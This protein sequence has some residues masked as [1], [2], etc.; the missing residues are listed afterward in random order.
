MK[1]L[2]II[3]PV[4]NEKNTL[5]GLL[6]S[7]ESSNIGPI[8]KE[9][10]IVD[11]FSTD[12]TRDL[13]R[14]LMKTN[15]YKIYFQDKNH[16]KGYA[17]RTGF[18]KAKGDY[19]LI[20]DADLEYNPKEYPN[21]LGPLIDG[22][23]DV[24]YGSRFVRNKPGGVL[25]FWHYV[26]NKFLTMFSN[27][28]TGLYLTD[29]E[30]C[31]KVF[32]KEAL[33]KIYPELRSDRFD[34]EPEITA[35][36]AEKR[37]RV[38]EVGVTYS[39]R[40]YDE[41]KKINWKDGFS[42]V[43]TIIK[44]KYRYSSFGKDKYKSTFFLLLILISLFSVLTLRP[45][46]AGDSLLYVDSIEV[47]KTGVQSAD[48]VPMMILTTYLGL[49]LIM[50]INY[51]TG[52]LAVSWILL[53]II[54]YI[55]TGVFFYS[56]LKRI[57]NDNKVAFIGSLFFATNYA[58]ITFGLGYLMDMGGWAAYIA[59]VYFS[60]RYL[61]TTERSNKF[62]YFSSILI[63]IGGLYKEY[64]FVAYAVVFGAILWKNWSNWKLII[65]KV[66]VTGLLSFTPFL[67]M[68]IFVF[69]KYN[70]YTYLDWYLFQKVYEFQ[71]RPVEFI[72]SF[73]S[74]YNFG[75]FLFLGGFYIFISKWKDILKDKKLV[76]ISLLLLSCSSVLLWPVV[77]R[78]LFITMPAVIIVSSL[79]I[80]KIEK[81][82]YLVYG[83]L[84][85]YIL[86]AYLMDSYILDFVNLRSIFPF[87]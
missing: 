68:S 83:L 19:I 52:S 28:L 59:S 62:I 76:F 47:L 86:S 71:N 74:I 30:T 87:L 70:H 51:F 58:I 42:A 14:E 17:L 35:V 60:Y 20:Q 18:S 49:R 32:T 34:I 45:K 11:D 38:Y 85:A 12:G 66:F 27:M 55:I 53:D 37:L 3:I 48:F 39:S 26:G 2:S 4:Y 63:G 25:F 44:S 13:L 1:T 46:I 77:T 57:L 82:I 24:V 75:W 50:F 29:M 64:A 22:E 31:Y 8:L 16:G 78:V 10:I 54:L 6:D 80:K 61:E 5:K 9:I 15:K 21:L 33:D 81:Y 69:F 23:A 43:W 73:G 7:V 65:K 36:V 84:G 79:F 67:L 40:T 72:K 56:L 41:G